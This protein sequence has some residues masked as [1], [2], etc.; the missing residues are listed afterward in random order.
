M[1]KKINNFL[2]HINSLLNFLQTN[3]KKI[4]LDDFAER[5]FI[6]FVMPLLRF[7]VSLQMGQV[8]TIEKFY[9]KKKNCHHFGA[10]RFFF[11]ENN[12]V[13][14]FFTINNYSRTFKQTKN[15]VPSY[16]Q[17][18]NQFSCGA[19][20]FENAIFLFNF[21]GQCIFFLALKKNQY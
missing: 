9:E 19:K 2:F 21:S 5:L 1:K 16:G 17:T 18:K 14:L 8:G 6:C 12:Q 7:S 13:H 4:Q 15:L 3:H 10:I 20:I 11:L